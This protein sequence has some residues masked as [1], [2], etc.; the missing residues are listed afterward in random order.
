MLSTMMQFPL[1]LTS[2][3]ERTGRLFGAAEIVSR[4]PDKSLYRSNYADLYRRSSASRRRA[5]GRRAG[6]WR[7]C[8]QPHVEPCVA[9]G[10]L[11]RGAGLRGRAPHAQPAASS[12]RIVVE[13]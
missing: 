4:L 5:R 7:A 11:F 8:C 1:T 12:G 9:S 6:S 13:A 2:I 3:L 10:G